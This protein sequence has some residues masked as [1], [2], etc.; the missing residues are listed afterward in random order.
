MMF[1]VL[2]VDTEPVWRGGQEQLL[3]L[4]MGLQEHGHQVHLA[5]PHEAPFVARAKEQGIPV[6]P[7]E[8]HTELSLK[9]ILGLRQIVSNFDCQ[10][11][12]VNT[13]KSILSCGLGT[14]GKGVVRVASRRVNFPLRGRLSAVKY[15][16]AVDAIFTVSASIRTGLIEQGVR[17]DKVVVVYEGV[18][19]EAIDRIEPVQLPFETSGVRI[20]IVSH[21]SGEKGHRDLIAALGEVSRLHPDTRC[22]IVGDGPLAEPLKQQARAQGLE[23]QVRFTG[24]RN[25]PE[26]VIKRLDIFC[27]PSL[28]EG[29]STAVMTAMACRVPV[30]ATTVGSLPELVPDGR[31]GVLVPPRDPSKLAAA[32]CRL[33]EEPETRRRLGLEGRRLI[34]ERFT[35]K[36]KVEATEHE[37]GRLLRHISIR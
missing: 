20:G 16:L 30:I 32:I 12:H 2:F 34:E 25:D 37:Y 4:L 3:T 11:V 29:L 1:R 14:L 19:P 31:S 22:Y 15:N 8:S 18:D 23:E 6:V 21:L 9:A 33:V 35:V 17:P 13:P 10:I 24:F 7:F 5:C 36:A 28:S 27:L 26:A